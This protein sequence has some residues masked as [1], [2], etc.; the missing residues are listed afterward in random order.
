MMAGRRAAL[1]GAALVGVV[2]VGLIPAVPAGGAGF[3]S[4][5]FEPPR[6]APDFA[7]T[8]AGGAEFQLSRARGKV[9]VLTFGYTNCPDVCPTVLAEL[10]Q[11]RARLGRDAGRV[12]VVY[13][14]VDPE[15]D[16]TER[17]RAY[18]QIFDKTFLGLTGPRA[19][20]EAVWK[21][22]GVSIV[23]REIPGGGPQA[24]G[25]HHTASIYVVD[26]AGQLRVMAPFGT[27]L[28]DVLH[29][30][31][32]VLASSAAADTPIRLEGSWVRRAPVM[33]DSPSNA[34]AYVTILNRGKAS[35]ALLSAMADVAASVELH[36]TRNMSGM[37][38]MERV[39]RIVVPAGARIELKPGA[40]HL[41]L[42]GL[43][44][45]LGPGQTVTLTLVFERA[46]PIATRAEVR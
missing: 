8:A 36:E 25:V 10:A 44:Q 27:P 24:Y 7:L 3:R 1:W 38:M 35:D 29:D 41:M 11:V 43:K 45:A 21:A 9:I 14:S 30:V 22:Y 23:R 6:P 13:V 40:H 17:L 16:T 42:T 4:G 15:R 28:D 34:A 46:G 26:A 32:L 19:Q 12:Q 20:L 5:A 2:L 37:M 18:V 33:P 39:P 31:R